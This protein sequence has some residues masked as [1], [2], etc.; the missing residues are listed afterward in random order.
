MNGLVIFCAVQTNVLVCAIREWTDCVR[1]VI[2]R[3]ADPS[4]V[5]CDYGLG[6]CSRDRGYL[7]GCLGGCSVSPVTL[8]RLVRQEKAILALLSTSLPCESL[9][10]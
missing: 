1:G 8:V 4:R 2:P 3:V 6:R 5:C 7:L 10:P 9:V